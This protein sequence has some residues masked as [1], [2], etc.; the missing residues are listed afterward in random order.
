MTKK[1]YYG[2]TAL[3]LLSLIVNFSRKALNFRR[4]GKKIEEKRGQLQ[5]LEAK[6]QELKRQMEEVDSPRFIE[7]EAREKLGLGKKDE[8]VVILPPIEPL[9]GE[10]SEAEK[11]VQN[12]QR[13]W[14]LF[15]Y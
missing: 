13:W 10:G 15:V 6:N 5:D 2:L 11:K 7:Q 1:L 4:A 12:W 9:R 14:Q 8:V 3:I